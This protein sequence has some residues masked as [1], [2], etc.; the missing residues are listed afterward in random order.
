M[1]QLDTAFNLYENKFQALPGI[2]NPN[3]RDV[4]LRQMVES[5]HRVKYVELILN[6]LISSR[7]ADPNDCLFD[8]IKAAI[9]R[10]RQGEIDDA[11]WLVFLFVHFGKHPKGGYRYASELYGKLGGG[12]WDWTNI[13]QNI[14]AFKAWWDS[15]YIIIKNG[16]PGGFG[17]HR[18]YE[19]LKHAANV[20]DSY[21]NWVQK[22]V[23]HQTLL[24]NAITNGGDPRKAFDILYHSMAKVMRFGRTARFDYL[25]MLGKLKIAPIIPGIAYLD[26]STG[27]VKGAQLLFGTGSTN[28]LSQWLVDLDQF[29][30]VGMQILEDSL[31]NW[32]KS[33]NTFKPFRG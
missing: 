31:C 11:C 8:P 2:N 6:R 4:L 16:G 3:I 1:Q 32:Q 14:S 29:L 10:L 20:V 22:G 25:T 27:P 26:D 18:K 28:E 7:R 19:S 33:P 12:R 9:I 23:D 13:S 21:I 24:N 17:N 5:F 30:N 15:N